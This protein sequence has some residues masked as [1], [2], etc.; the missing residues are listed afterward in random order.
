M[1]YSAMVLETPQPPHHRPRRIKFWM[2]G[3]A[4]AGGLW[5]FGLVSF[6]AADG[7]FEMVLPR[8]RT[9]PAGVH[10][11]SL[12]D[13]GPTVRASTFYGDWGS[14]HHPAFL[15]DGR[16][17][18][19]SIEKWASAER[20]RHPWI[21]IL[22]RENHDLERVVIRH[23]GSVESEGMTAN[24]YTLRC[25]MASGQGPSLEIPANKDSI[26]SHDLACVQARGLRIE[27]VPKGGQDNKDSKDSKDIIRIFEV[28][29]WGR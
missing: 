7:H 14:T 22:W 11:F 8:Q 23:A 3:L 1:W 15:V 27:F 26:A 28:E 21:E 4:I 17:S 20:D 5:L 6:V 2:L 12:W 9:P 10:N 25:L 16:T 13:L 18:P 24:H 29:T 19:D